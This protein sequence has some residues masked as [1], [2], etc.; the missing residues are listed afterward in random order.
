[1]IAAL[2]V[3]PKRYSCQYCGCDV[4]EL[5]TLGQSMRWVDT[6]GSTLCPSWQ[7]VFHEVSQIAL[8]LEVLR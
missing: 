6:R 1:M 4:S 5:E 3:E 2:P 8:P 7:S